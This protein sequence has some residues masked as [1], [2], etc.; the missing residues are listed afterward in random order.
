LNICE[1]GKQD[2]DRHDMGQDVVK[3]ILV[4]RYDHTIYLGRKETMLKR[5]RTNPIVEN[6]QILILEFE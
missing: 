1:L 5:N 6:T 3:M 4:N 2:L